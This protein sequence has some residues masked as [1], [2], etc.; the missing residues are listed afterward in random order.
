MESSKD[1][2][3]IEDYKWILRSTQTKQIIQQQGDYVGKS[4]FYVALKD[5]ENYLLFSSR[6]GFKLYKDGLLFYE[7]KDQ[8]EDDQILKGVIYVPKHNC[9]LIDLNNRVYRKDVNKHKIYIFIEKRYAESWNEVKY[10]PETDRLLYDQFYEKVAVVNPL[11]KRHEIELRHSSRRD[12]SIK[13]FGFFGGGS[14][15]GLMVIVLY[16][17]LEIGLFRAICNPGQ[18]RGMLDLY[19]IDSLLGSVKEETSNIALAGNGRTFCVALA[20]EVYLYPTRIIIFSI[21]EDDD[22]IIEK[23]QVNLYGLKRA[24]IFRGIFQHVFEEEEKEEGD[25]QKMFFVAYTTLNMLY[26]TFFLFEYDPFQDELKEVERRRAKFCKGH[27][28]KVC[29]LHRKEYFFHSEV[30]GVRKMALENPGKGLGN[31]L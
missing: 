23:A 22:S 4:L 14:P 2:V 15:S 27:P 3:P 9:Y 19:E 6:C 20:E 8:Y 13:D 10:C 26:G 16:D 31:N 25:A 18:K 29:Q 17:E 21:S 7:K 1:K 24:R 5:E 11:T 28:L 30:A 12:C